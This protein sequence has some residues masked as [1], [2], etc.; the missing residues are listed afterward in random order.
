MQVLDDWVIPLIHSASEEIIRFSVPLCCYQIQGY[1]VAVD[2]L[3]KFRQSPLESR[4]T[5]VVNQVNN[6]AMLVH[7]PRI[8]IGYDGVGLDILTE[9]SVVWV[10][11]CGRARVSQQILQNL[12]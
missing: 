6:E 8:L 10:R 1:L 4:Q 2:A 11:G 9:S 7:Q 5:S 12:D 3:D